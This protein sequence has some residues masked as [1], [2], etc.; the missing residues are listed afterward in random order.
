MKKKAQHLTLRVTKAELF[1]L[2]EAVNEK[3]HGPDPFGMLDTETKAALYGAI[4]KAE[5]AIME[6]HAR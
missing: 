2:I 4:R 1:A 3:L 6:A 5:A